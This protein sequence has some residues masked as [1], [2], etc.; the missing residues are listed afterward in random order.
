MARRRT[1]QELAGIPEDFDS[2]AAALQRIGREL[3]QKFAELRQERRP[4]RD[5]IID[6][7]RAGNPSPPPAP[8]PTPEEVN[9][10]LLSGSLMLT[11]SGLPQVADEPIRQPTAADE[12]TPAVQRF[13]REHSML[14]AEVSVYVPQLTQPQLYA[15]WLAFNRQE[16][17]AQIMQQLRSYGL[18]TQDADQVYDIVEDYYNRQ[19]N[20]RAAA[21]AA[22][23][24]TQDDYLNLTDNLVLLQFHEMAGISDPRVTMAAWQ[25]VKS[26]SSEYRLEVLAQ[27]IGETAPTHARMNGVGALLSNLLMYRT[28]LRIPRSAAALQAIHLVINR[29]RILNHLTEDQLRQIYEA[30]SH[31]NR[32]EGAKAI[33]NLPFLRDAS[34]GSLIQLREALRTRILIEQLLAR[35]AGGPA[36]EGVADWLERGQGLLERGANLLKRHKKLAIGGAALAVGATIML[37]PKNARAAAASTALR[38]W[39]QQW[40]DWPTLSNPE[41]LRRVLRFVNEGLGD[42]RTTLGDYQDLWCGAFAAWLFADTLHPRIRLTSF[43]STL[44]LQ[45]LGRYESSFM[46]ERTVVLKDG[47]RQVLREY[48]KNHGGERLYQEPAKGQLAWRPQ[49]GDL[50]L[51]G[52]SRSGNPAHV[53]V[54]KSYDAQTG[55]VQT[56]SGNGGGV[57][58]QGQQAYGVVLTAY[59][60]NKIQALVRLAPAD[61]DQ[62]LKFA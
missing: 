47:E 1:R 55:I 54:V 11:Q 12:W 33:R 23:H 59:P 45:A 60:I 34:S 13:V 52:L 57:G 53:T 36:I 3:D 25:V 29:E 19:A 58:P 2:I 62:S 4:A 61:F 5:R 27:Y 38:R 15:V 26:N 8:G 14:M 16:S 24:A 6:R 7:L 22:A 44:R 49:A 56:I 40:Q 10:A 9:R 39:Q 20:E 35:E 30:G 43:A 31:P 42:H 32:V 41:R 48:H 50:A 18:G 46:P 17:I 28:A 51:V 37:W 21:I